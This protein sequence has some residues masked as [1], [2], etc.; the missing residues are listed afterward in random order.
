MANPQAGPSP[1][2]LLGASVGA[3]VSAG[4]LL[5]YVTDSISVTALVL[6]GAL[7]SS[8]LFLRRR[9]LPAQLL[10]R[11]LWGAGAILGGTS[12]AL[13]DG[14][15]AAASFAG[16]AL[17]LVLLSGHGLRHEETPGF[18]PARYRVPLL[19]SLILSATSALLFGLFSMAAFEVVGVW[20]LNL[21]TILALT[22]GAVGL[23]RM[24]TWG[25]LLLAGANGL[26]VAQ[27]AGGNVL[28]P[29]PLQAWVTL[30]ASASLVGLAPMLA[31]AFT[32]LRRTPPT[33]TERVRVATPLA[34]DAPFDAATREL[35]AEREHDAAAEHRLRVATAPL[36]R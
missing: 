35:E 7:G 23:A 12:F 22:A 11:A 2:R 24:K 21:G 25:L 13:G 4:G 26:I 15:G 16:S 8:A 30:L 31:H 17:A 33:S 20:S 36:R 5:A 3:L 27:A 9:S 1:L 6:A 10:S 34:R 28:L 14:P 32:H 29:M 18:Q 19:L